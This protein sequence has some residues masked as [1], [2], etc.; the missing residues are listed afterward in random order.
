MRNIIVN[1]GNIDLSFFENFDG[2]EDKLSFKLIGI[3]D[4]LEYL[5]DIPYRKFEDL[6]MVPICM[7]RKGILP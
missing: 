6:A 7:V 5:E 2:V 4:N 3:K 1:N